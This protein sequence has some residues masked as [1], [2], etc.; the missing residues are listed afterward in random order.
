MLV[1]GTKHRHHTQLLQRLN[2]QPAIRAF[3]FSESRS[4]EASGRS[5]N[6]QT[7]QL[8]RRLAHSHR[9]YDSFD[10]LGN[11]FA[12][13]G[14]K[15]DYALTSRLVLRGRFGWAAVLSDDKGYTYSQSSST[16]SLWQGGLGAD[17]RMTRHL[18]L[19]AGGDYSYSHIRHA[20][21]SNTYYSNS[22]GNVSIFGTESFSRLRAHS[23]S[24]SNDLTLHAGLAYQF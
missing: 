22:F 23:S 8:Q 5:A 19:T 12:G 4:S 1:D 14:I 13:A 17:Y 18:H 6:R 3:I 20:D 21:A 10:D 16:H 24:L 11:F 15:A 9:G 2:S 7:R